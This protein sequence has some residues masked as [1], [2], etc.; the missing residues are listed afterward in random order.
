LSRITLLNTVIALTVFA[1]NFCSHFTFLLFARKDFTDSTI[2]AAKFRF[3]LRLLIVHL[4][5]EG[6]KE[7]HQ[8]QRTHATGY[9]TWQ[10]K[11]AST[12]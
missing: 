2:T 10:S 8:S 1:S 4:V 6:D 3:P 11:V 5:Y 7:N 12:G 9:Q